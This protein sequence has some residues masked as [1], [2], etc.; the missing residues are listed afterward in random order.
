MKETLY[1]KGRTWFKKGRG[2]EE[3]NVGKFM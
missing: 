1:L 3:W 2:G